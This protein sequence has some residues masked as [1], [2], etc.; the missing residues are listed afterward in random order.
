MRVALVTSVGTWDANATL[1]LNVH[2]PSDVPR[3]ADDAPDDP[4][5]RLERYVIVRASG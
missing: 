4:A 3:F 1:G 5:G 2:E